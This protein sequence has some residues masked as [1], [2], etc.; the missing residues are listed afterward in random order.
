MRI[1]LLVLTFSSI[2]GCAGIHSLSHHPLEGKTVAIHASLP[3]APFADFSMT[4]F[5]KVGNEIPAF[6]RNQPPPDPVP[7][8]VIN[9]PNLDEEIVDGERTPTHVIIDSVL[10]D[11]NMSDQILAFTRTL[12][13]RQL[14]F[15]PVSDTEEADYTLDL[16]IHDYGIGADSWAT[17]VFFELSATVTLIDNTSGRQIWQEEMQDFVTVTKALL[18]AGAP[19]EQTG[20]P[21]Q[22]GQKSFDEMA[23]LLTA[24]ALYSADQITLPLR[25][26]YQQTV[27][28]DKANLVE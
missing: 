10:T 1:L 16:E 8:L 13:A 2:A 17:T 18:Q 27:P 28:R 4:I 12:G 23:D 20:T 5:D 24:L 21:A 15:I 6:Q 26:A 9:T 14:Q 3:D 11:Q 25:D 19:Q 22:L 7:A